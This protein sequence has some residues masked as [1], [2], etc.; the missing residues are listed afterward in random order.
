MLDTLRKIGEQLLE[1]QGVWAQLSTEPSYNSRKEKHWICPILF[2]CVNKEIQVL[3]DELQLFKPDK[4][5]VDFRYLNPEKWGR[6]GKKCALT[7]E[8]KKF[9]M[10]EE[11][12]FGKEGDRVGTMLASIEEFDEELKSTPIYVALEEINDKLSDERSKL[13]IKEIKK[14]LN[15]SNQDEV[16]LF[17]SKI[18]SKQ[19]D[20][21]ESANLFELGG[22]EDFV[23]GKFAT[24]D[25]SSEGLD[26]LT[27]NL[28]EEVVEASFTGRRN[29][30]KVFQMTAS[31]YAS[32][33]SDFK[34][35]YQSSPLKLAALD[36]ASEYFLDNEIYIADIP[37]IVVPNFLSKDLDDIDLEK[38][39]F[40]I[41]KTSEL[42][43]QL[44]SFNE[45]ILR[46]LY[47]EKIFWI[48]YVAFESVGNEFKIINHIKDVNNL[49][50]QKVIQVFYKSGIDYQDYIGGD[51]K[52]NLLSIYSI[53]PIRDSKKRSKI[54]SV[55]TLF[56]GI[57]EQQLISS[58]NL[59][60]HFVK[61]ISI[62]R[63][64]SFKNGKSS[65]FPNLKEK[66]LFDY[67]VK[68]GVF[69][70]LAL[71]NALEQLNLLSMKHDESPQ[72]V[73][74][75]KSQYPDEQVDEFLSLKECSRNQVALFCLG[76]A[77]NIVGYAQ[78]RKNHPSKPIL[79]KVNFKGIEFQE[80]NDLF[81]ALMEKGK[82]YQTVKT[83]NGKDFQVRKHIEKWLDLY[84]KY[85]DDKN[86]VLR[87][88]EAV[89]YLLAG[90]V[91]RPSSNYS[92]EK[93]N[94]SSEEN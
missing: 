40:F 54:N 85:L 50:L 57:L 9:S 94:K 41:D 77:L 45:S 12:L 64:G 83:K 18:K 28:S 72:I 92:D 31:N 90:Y 16:V 11:T 2:D 74:Q 59:F 46:K 13:D 14:T 79:N 78:E 26:Y 86:W 65:A 81:G 89:F 5:K 88:E 22:Y 8:S 21:D 58:E 6:N 49:Y 44:N 48:N 70:Y 66:E 69:N 47:D 37:H 29:L 19:I 62:H 17:Y 43:F 82:Q 4:T 63:H 33:F 25:K 42:L 76:R 39:E 24:P 10:L 32:G 51:F 68:D 87:K 27:G 67:A 84:S 30:N 53:I 71:F 61:F 35:N 60:S 20:Q 3:R 1:G 56:K 55:L 75:L 7:I 23:I 34:K 93:E 38:V 52:F 36:K 73:N 91:F 80:A 15:L